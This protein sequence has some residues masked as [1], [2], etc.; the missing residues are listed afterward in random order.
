MA[1]TLTITVLRTDATRAQVT[2]PITA[3]LNNLKDAISS[4]SL[5]PIEREHQRLFHLGREL[6]SGGRSLGALGF[7]KHD[8]F[9]VHLHSTKPKTLEL[10]SDEEDDD[11]VVLEGVISGPSSGDKRGCAMSSPECVE[12]VD[13]R[14]DESDDDVAVVETVPTSEGNKRRRVR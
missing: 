12:V 8:N 10:S 13:L 14:E 5:G 1:D 6:K 3:T 4:T 2:L 7:G 11:D 9:L